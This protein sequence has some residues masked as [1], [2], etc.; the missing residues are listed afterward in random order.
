MYFA[1]S[2][3]ADHHLNELPSGC[4][5]PS[6]VRSTVPIGKQQ[7]H[8][9]LFQRVPCRIGHRTEHGKIESLLAALVLFDRVV[10]A[11]PEFRK[12]WLLHTVQEPSLEGKG[13]TVFCDRPMPGGTNRYGGKLVMNSLLPEDAELRKIGG[14]GKEF[15]VENTGTNY[16]IEDPTKHLP[17][18][19]AAWR[20]EIS[21]MQARRDDEFLTV[22]TVMDAETK[23]VSPVRRIDGSNVVGVVD[24]LRIVCIDSVHAGGDS[25]DVLLAGGGEGGRGDITSV[26]YIHAIDNSLRCK[27]NPPLTPPRRGTFSF[28]NGLFSMTV[29]EHKKPKNSPFLEGSGVGSRLGEL[30]ILITKH[31]CIS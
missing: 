1:W 25:A 26:G 22:L 9:C 12:T 3:C 16:A 20:V 10:A 14:P 23:G 11:R 4:E 5:L 15:W 7:H 18:D 19:L 29:A 27:G 31:L 13:A 24:Y 17:D 30:T 6:A 28:S 8:R 21:P 2:H